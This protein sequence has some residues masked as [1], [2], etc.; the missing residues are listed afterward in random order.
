MLSKPEFKALTPSWSQ[1]RSQSFLILVFCDHGAIRG[2][3][4][5]DRIFLNPQGTD[6]LKFAMV[7]K[8]L[9]PKQSGKAMLPH[10]IIL[11]SLWHS[12][13]GTPSVTPIWSHLAACTHAHVQIERKG[14]EEGKEGR[15]RGRWRGKERLKINKWNKESLC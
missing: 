10:E 7:Y 9:W 13:T 15:K 14:E 11:S 6:D 8:R 12:C 1:A 4:C 3:A 5:R 2:D